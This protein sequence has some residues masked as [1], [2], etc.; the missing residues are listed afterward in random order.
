MMD[1]KEKNHY[2]SVELTTMLVLCVT[3]RKHVM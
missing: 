2:K 3:H 1:F